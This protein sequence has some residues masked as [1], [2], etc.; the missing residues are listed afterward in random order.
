MIAELKKR[1]VGD[2]GFINT[3]LIDAIEVEFH[4]ENTEAN[5]LRSLVINEHKDIILFP[6]NFKW[7]LLSCGIIRFPFISPGYSN[8]ILMNYACVRSFHYI[9]LEIK[10]EQGVVTVLD[11]RRKDP[12]DYAD[13]TAMLQK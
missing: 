9:L 4:A 6:Y 7:V 12:H 5:L 2:I 1:Q 8:V 11:S 10:L 13:I 3:Y